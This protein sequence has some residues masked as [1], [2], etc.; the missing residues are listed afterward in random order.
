MMTCIGNN[1]TG[2]Y[3]KAG[4]SGTIEPRMVDYVL[5]P[6]QPEEELSK[7]CGFMFT[8]HPE[9]LMGRKIAN[10]TAF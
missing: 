5:Y 4:S 9:N 7:R 3:S 1:C 2:V 8:A 10:F 6:H